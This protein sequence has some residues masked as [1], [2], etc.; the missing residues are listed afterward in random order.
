MLHVWTFVGWGINI[1]FLIKVIR[2]IEISKL[3]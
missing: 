3:K 1:F 2:L